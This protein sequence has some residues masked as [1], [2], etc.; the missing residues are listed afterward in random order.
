VGQL[1]PCIVAGGRGWG[2][3]EPTAA[4]AINEKRYKRAILAE[5]FSRSDT[6]RQQALARFILSSHVAAKQLLRL[7]ELK[8]DMRGSL[9]SQR[10]LDEAT[11]M[12]K[13]IEESIIDAMD[14]SIGVEFPPRVDGGGDKLLVEPR[15]CKDCA[16]FRSL[17]TGAICRRYLSAVTPT[18]N[19]TYR[20]ADGTCFR[21]RVDGG[22]A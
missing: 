4:F 12:C 22:G 5:M 20:E 10:R 11:E 16:H 21:H 3:S 14:K 7:T 2:V 9:D 19:A 6:A 17:P 15:E 8:E 13:Y 1:C 18:M